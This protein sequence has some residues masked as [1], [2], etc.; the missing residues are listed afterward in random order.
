MNERCQ[1]RYDYK[2][3][4][5]KEDGGLYYRLIAVAGK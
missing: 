1:K 4:L 2:E 3:H 5:V